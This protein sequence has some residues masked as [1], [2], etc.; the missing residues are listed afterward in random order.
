MESPLG[1]ILANVFMAKLENEPLVSMIDQI[2]FYCPYVD[3]TFVACQNTV[4]IPYLVSAENN[5]HRAIQFPYEKEDSNHTPLWDVSLRRKHD[6]NLSH[7]LYFKT[8]QYSNFSIFL[9]MIQKRNLV[10]KT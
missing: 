5:A 1:L 8:G 7:L 4:E 2:H 6:E 3:D 9:P 10:K